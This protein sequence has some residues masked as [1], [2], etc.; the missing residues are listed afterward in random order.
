MIVVVGLTLDVILIKEHYL[1]TLLKWCS[2]P[3]FSYLSWQLL[4]GSFKSNEA[5]H[6]NYFGKHSPISFLQ[7][8]L[9]QWINP[10]AWF[11]ALGAISTFIDNDQ[12]RGRQ[13][14]LVAFYFWIFALPCTLIWVSI[15]NWVRKCF[16]NPSRLRIFNF[17]AAALLIVSLAISVIF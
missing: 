1:Y 3:Y 11:I 12:E 6:S 14:L 15:G 5:D 4:G 17:S 10:K 7:A 16:D 8:A 9:F 2:L 13:A